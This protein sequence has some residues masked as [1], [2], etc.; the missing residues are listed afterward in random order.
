[1]MKSKILSI[2]AS[3]P[4]PSVLAS[5]GRD[6]AEVSFYKIF[7]YLGVAPPQRS[8]DGVPFDSLA[9]LTRSGHEIIASRSLRSLR[10]ILS[11]GERR[12]RLLFFRFVLK[13]EISDLHVLRIP[14]TTF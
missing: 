10:A 1:M 14:V 2:V 7:P 5:L 11:W 9:A 3:D 13:L 12:R 4:A 6:F 8:E